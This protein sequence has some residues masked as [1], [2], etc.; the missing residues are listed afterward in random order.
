MWQDEPR[1]EVLARLL[2]LS[3]E[4]ASGEAGYSARRLP[5]TKRDTSSKPDGAAWRRCLTGST[6]LWCRSKSK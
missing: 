2:A 4:R 3:A 6:A 1:D 5:K